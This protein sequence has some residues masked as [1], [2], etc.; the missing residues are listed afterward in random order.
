MTYDEAF[1]AAVLG[2]RVRADNMGEGVYVDYN[3]NGLRINF[4]GG[5]SSG[6]TARDIDEA[7]NWSIVP[8]ASEIKRDSWGRIV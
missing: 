2:D 8:L 7:A 5:S 6:W 3:F 1:D 4:P